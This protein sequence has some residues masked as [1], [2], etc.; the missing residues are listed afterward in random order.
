M[1]IGLVGAPGS[2]KTTLAARLFAQLKESG[3]NDAILVQEYAREYVAQARGLPAL[4]AQIE[5]TNRQF[6]REIEALYFSPVVCDSCLWLGGIYAAR[7][8]IRTSPA[9]EAYLERLK[10]YTY[11][12][13]ILVPLFDKKQSIKERGRGHTVD[14]SSLIEDEITKYLIDNSIPFVTAPNQISKRNKFVRNFINGLP[15]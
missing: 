12:Y 14:E 9:L 7:S 2:G 11:D 6:G 5:I 3:F 13:T 15:K 10:T 4:K 1:R 8:T